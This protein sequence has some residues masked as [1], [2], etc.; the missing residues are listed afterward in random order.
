M[1][2]NAAKAAWR[3]LSSSCHVETLIEGTGAAVPI[4]MVIRA[5]RLFIGNLE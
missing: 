1:R 4:P 5:S 2:Q 3:P